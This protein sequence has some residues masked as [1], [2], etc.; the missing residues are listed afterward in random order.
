MI[1][2]TVL[3]PSHQVRDFRLLLPG[4]PGAFAHGLVLGTSREVFGVKNRL[5]PVEAWIRHPRAFLK[6]GKQSPEFPRSSI[7]L[8]SHAARFLRCSSFLHG[9]HINITS[10]IKSPSKEKVR[11]VCA[12]GARRQAQV[13]LHLGP[14]NR[15]V[16][17]PHA[18]PPERWRAGRRATDARFLRKQSRTGG[19]APTINVKGRRSQKARR[20][21]SVGA[22]KKA[23]PV[24]PPGRAGVSHSRRVPAEAGESVLTAP[25]VLVF[26]CRLSPRRQKGTRTA[27]AGAPSTWT[28]WPFLPAPSIRGE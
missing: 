7:F 13:G 20:D 9:D 4:F 21:A 5:S 11:V 12:P 24:T 23:S 14:Q 26:R 3:I 8:T 16:T 6:R 10:P 17:R 1:D 28:T 18:G 25:T 15:S 19:L 2:D 22:F 27:S